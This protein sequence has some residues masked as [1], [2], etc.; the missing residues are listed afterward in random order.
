MEAAQS[1]HQPA[2]DPERIHITI[3][4]H[5]SRVYN[6]PN[7][8]Y[9]APEASDPP[10]SSPALA[11]PHQQFE[12]ESR[13]RTG[14]NPRVGASCTTSLATFSS[15]LALQGGFQAEPSDPNGRVVATAIRVDWCFLSERGLAARRLRYNT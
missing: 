15:P 8:N 1:F 7:H 9:D 2:E 14:Y 12:Y 5:R 13:H 11:E 10:R 4:S 3:T 6:S